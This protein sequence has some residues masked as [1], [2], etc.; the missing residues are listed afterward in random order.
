MT[1]TDA[2]MVAEHSFIITTTAMLPLGRVFLY[3]D[4]RFGALSHIK[5][6]A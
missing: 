6:A 4:A 1:L 2:I 5:G 3:F